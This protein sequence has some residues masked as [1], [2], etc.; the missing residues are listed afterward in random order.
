MIRFIIQLVCLGAACRLA[1]AAD[2]NTLAS[3]VRLETFTGWTN[4]PVLTG[5]D[6]RLVALPLVGGRIVQYS[7]N[8][9]NVLYEES[10]SG[11]KTLA[12]SPDGFAMGG[13]QCDLAPEA[14]SLAGRK[15]FWL[16]P[17]RWKMPQPQALVLQ[18]EPE[19]A[20]LWQMSKEVMMDPDTG[21]IG[22]Q[23]RVT[24]VSKSP[25]A[26][27]LWDRTQCKG[28][29]F[30]LIPLNR[31]SRLKMGWGMTRPDAAGKAHYETSQPSDPRARVL[32]HVLVIEAKGGPLTVGADSDQEW[33]A[34]TVGRLL[35]VKYHPYF[36]RGNYAEGGSSVAFACGDRRAELQAFSPETTLQ[37]GESLGFPEKWA[38][39][40]LERSVS[41]FAE[42]RA[43]VKRIRL[44]PFKK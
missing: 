27:C 40:D 39:L 10:G 41:S 14:R 30:A 6:C 44:S 29:G 11:G 9:E 34:Y 18:S 33:M 21:E 19:P 4:S 35:L 7:L 36:P 8:G 32:D 13:Y 38:L 31:K 5:G 42:A 16:G 43:L 25:A 1:A 24:N 23:Q 17:W 22:L 20:A 2:T 26:A 15:A 12:G 28:G 3:G 37:P